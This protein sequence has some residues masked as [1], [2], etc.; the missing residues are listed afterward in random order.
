MTTSSS[1]STT[2][3]PCIS[4]SASATPSTASPDSS[5]ATR[6]DGAKRKKSGLHDIEL[7]GVALDWNV[8][9]VDWIAS[10]TSLEEV[11]SIHTVQGY[12][13]NYAGVIIGGDLRIDPGTGLLVAD[14]KNYF[15]A[16]GK[17][18]N[19][20]RGQTTT[21]NDLPRYITNV[22]RVLLTRGMRGT[23]VFAVDAE[24]RARLRNIASAH[25]AGQHHQKSRL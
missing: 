4:G 19:R 10:K 5:P 24:L 16:K 7:D 8:S 18:S 2:S 17:A 11:G 23:Y 15:D 12:D 21:D 14:R 20:T 22:Y 3:G 6:G 25:L 9:D 13:L 1:C